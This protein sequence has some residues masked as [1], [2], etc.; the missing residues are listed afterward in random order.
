MYIFFYYLHFKY[1]NI[2]AI[3]NPQISE[4]RRY[5]SITHLQ[6][7]KNVI[8]KNGK[9]GSLKGMCSDTSVNN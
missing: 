7:T 9:F 2:L 6:I 3:Q 4:R 8:K 1:K 5:N